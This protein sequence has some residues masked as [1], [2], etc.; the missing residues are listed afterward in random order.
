MKN[1]KTKK[2]QGEDVLMII[3]T[4]EKSQYLLFDFTN[5]Q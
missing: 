4:P 5:S 3:P 1:E 2:G